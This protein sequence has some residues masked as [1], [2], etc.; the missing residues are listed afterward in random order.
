MPELAEHGLR[1][2]D[3]GEVLEASDLAVIVTAHPEVDHA[4]IVRRAPVT[5][6]LRGV[7]RA[8]REPSAIQL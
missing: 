7:T 6:D 2:S 8:L 1:S 5:L 3:L 4:A